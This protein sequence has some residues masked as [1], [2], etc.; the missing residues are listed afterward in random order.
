V[1]NSE[2]IKT[3]PAKLSERVSSII[4]HVESAENEHQYVLSEEVVNTLIVKVDAESMAIMPRSINNIEG[5]A[6][7]AYWATVIDSDKKIIL[8]A[9]LL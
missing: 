8:T 1:K 7:V 5:V 3:E 2:E 4:Q 6:T 9:S